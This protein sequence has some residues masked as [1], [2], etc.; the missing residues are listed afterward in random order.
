MLFC[1]GGILTPTPQFKGAFLNEQN[2][3]NNYS[4]YLFNI[5][6]DK[7]HLVNFINPGRLRNAIWNAYSIPDCLP[8]CPCGESREELIVSQS[9]KNIV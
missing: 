3:S 8:S 5:I 7:F 1:Q 6:W 4:A 2:V 9:W